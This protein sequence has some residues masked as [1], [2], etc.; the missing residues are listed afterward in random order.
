MSSKGKAAGGGNRI[1]LKRKELS[2]DDPL[3]PVKRRSAR[4]SSPS[5]AAASS[6]DPIELLSDGDDEYYDDRDAVSDSDVETD[7]RMAEIDSDED[8]RRAANQDDTVIPASRDFSQLTLKP[9]HDRRPIWVCP[10]GRVFLDTRSAIYKQAYDFLIAISDP[11]CRPQF[12]HEYQITSYSLY[13]AASLGLQT[14]DIVSGLTRLS[15]VVLDERLVEFIR[16]KTL[17]CGKVK[18]VLHKTRY[19]VESIYPDVLNELLKQDVIAEARIDDKRKS[20]VVEVEDEK[21]AP[22]AL[23]APKSSLYADRQ[24]ELHRNNKYAARTVA[25]DAGEDASL[26]RDAETGFLMAVSAENEAALLLPGTNGAAVDQRAAM[27][28][29]EF[30]RVVNE[31]LPISTKLLSFELAAN[32]VEDVR[33]RCNDIS[34]PM[35]EEYDFRRDTSTPDLPI[36]LKPSAQIR[37]YQEKSLSKMFGNGRSR[38]GIIV[39]PCGAGKTL[40]G[41]TAAATVKKSTLVFCTTGVAVDQWRRQFLHWSTLP[42]KYICQFTSSVKDKCVTD[43]VVL[44]TTY[45]MVSFVGKRSAA[46]DE[47][48]SLITSQEWGLVICGTKTQLTSLHCTPPVVGSMSLTILSL[49]FV[50]S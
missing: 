11:V 25:A 18:L 13:A 12:I 3:E 35:L 49:T 37:D 28:L 46:A 6:S 39:L 26:I 20:A 1:T 34:Y 4:S 44:I 5:P 7:H 33:R 24:A 16:E 43:S 50:S 15:K 47:V 40:V 42:S 21:A 41:I 45:N 30:E 36:H 32:K 17:K 31:D 22:T 8:E 23:A 19:Y 14:D 27:G 29:A 9:D 48:M 2:S 38:S 10:N